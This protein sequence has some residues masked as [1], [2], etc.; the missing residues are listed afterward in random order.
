MLLQHPGLPAPLNPFSLVTASALLINVFLWSYPRCVMPKN[1]SV[2][3]LELEASRFLTPTSFSTLFPLHP[4]FY[5]SLVPTDY[6][7]RW[8]FCTVAAFRAH[9]LTPLLIQPGLRGPSSR[10]LCIVILRSCAPLFLHLTSSA[11]LP[12]WWNLVLCL[13]H[14]E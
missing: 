14:V 8:H 12:S 5:N 10:S 2:P 7:T 11:K 3:I 6:T 1:P 13:P 9:V 4:S